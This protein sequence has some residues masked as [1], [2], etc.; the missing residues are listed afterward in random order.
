MSNTF[1]EYDQVILFQCLNFVVFLNTAE[2]FPDIN[3][4]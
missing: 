4:T 1:R 2:V 3:V